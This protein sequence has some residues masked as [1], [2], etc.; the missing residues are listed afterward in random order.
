PLA[1][2]AREGLSRLVAGQ[3]E[4]LGYGGRREDRHGRLL[5]HLWV[6]GVWVQGEM[7]A[8]GLARVSTLPDARALG[9]DMLAREAE[10][11]AAG[12]G[13]WAEP[14]YAVRPAD[15]VDA[16]AEAGRF[17]I[18]EGQV[19]EAAA[20]GRRVYLNFGAD[21]RSD[22]TAVVVPAARPLFSAEGLDPL[23]LAGRTVRVR[24]WVDALNGPMIEVTH[25]E[26]IEVV[27]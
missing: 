10:A 12:R 16:G 7:L 2:A 23:A 27:R 17:A 21:Y 13:L 9:R 1:E 3:T 19:R 24:G 6:D 4:R 25:P 18:V 15:A 26:Q 8:R 22:F 14:I 20:V 5:A 11:R